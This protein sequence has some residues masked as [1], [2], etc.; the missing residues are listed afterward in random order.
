M[1]E[2]IK[3]AFP[4]LSLI[5]EKITGGS[6]GISSIN[7]GYALNQMEISYCS[8]LKASIPEMCVCVSIISL[9][10]TKGIRVSK[11]RAIYRKY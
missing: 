8:F 7:E 1:Y 6:Y 5:N 3:L 4:L 9:S 11:K 10:I 2:K